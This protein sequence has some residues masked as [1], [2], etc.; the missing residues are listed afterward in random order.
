MVNQRNDVVERQK[1]QRLNLEQPAA[2]TGGLGGAQ[3]P[4]LPTSRVEQRYLL[5]FDMKNV[6]DVHVLGQFIV[7]VFPKGDLVD[8]RIAR[9]RTDNDHYNG[10]HAWL[11]LN[12]AVN[13][14]YEHLQQLRT[15]GFSKF[16]IR[17]FYLVNDD[18]E[19]GDAEISDLTDNPLFTLGVFKD[20]IPASGGAASDVAASASRVDNSTEII[21]AQEARMEA[22]QRVIDSYKVIETNQNEIIANKEEI[23]QAQ[24]QTSLALAAEVAALKEFVSSQKTVIALLKPGFEHP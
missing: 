20:G 5:F 22:M 10:F 23:I 18:T 12:T 19:L 7:G 11:H 4:D 15:I 17:K 13:D 6:K 2:A 8:L 1:R 21:A 14:E 24:A 16:K 3:G 9:W